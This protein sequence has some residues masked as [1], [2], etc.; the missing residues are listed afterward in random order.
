MMAQAGASM[1]R[2][3]LPS[4]RCGRR[5]SLAALERTKTMRAGKVLDAVGPHFIKSTSSIKR[6]S[7]TS[8]GSQARCVR[9]SKKS[10]LSAPASSRS[11]ML[12]S[13]VAPSIAKP[14]S[15]TTGVRR[16][17]RRASKLYRPH[18][19][20]IRTEVPQQVF[21]AVTQGCGRAG[22]TSAGAAHMQEHDAILVAVKHDIAA[23]IGNGGTHAG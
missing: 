6:L 15:C 21:D 1:V 3:R 8:I 4:A 19:A 2:S 16:S 17:L 7:G 5:R 23:V 13:Q 10:C 14:R 22:A 18:L 9:A 20:H 11:P 12:A